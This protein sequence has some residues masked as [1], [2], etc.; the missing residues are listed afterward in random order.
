MRVGDLDTA[1]QAA[2]FAYHHARELFD[3]RTLTHLLAW[4]GDLTGHVYVNHTI[5]EMPVSETVAVRGNLVRL[6]GD[7]LRVVASPHKALDPSWQ[8]VA[9]AQV[10]PNE[11]FVEWKLENRRGTSFQY[12]RLTL[13]PSGASEVAVSRDL[14]LGG[15]RFRGVSDPQ[16]PQP[17]RELAAGMIADDEEM[18]SAEGRAYHFVLHDPTAAPSRLRYQPDGA[19]QLQTVA[20]IAADGTYYA[21]QAG[22]GL[23]ITSQASAL[24]LPPLPAG[25][26]YLDVHVATQHGGAEWIIA[27]W[28]QTQFYRVAIAGITTLSLHAGL[29]SPALGRG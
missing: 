18:E 4:N 5:A 15:Y 27:V 22:A 1:G 7:Q 23:L 28:E 25:L 14:F 11:A 13:A 26:R 6:S 12:T 20:M 16:V 17:L 2:P 8:S 29:P 19:T 9:L 21:L 24:Q 3:Q 10:A